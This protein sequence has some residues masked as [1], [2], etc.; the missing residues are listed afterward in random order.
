[1]LLAAFL[2]FYALDKNGYTNE[3]YA[4][5]VK[6]QLVSW[7]NFFFNAYDPAGFITLDKPPVAFWLETASAWLFGYS[8]VSI[9]IPSALAGMGS[10]LLVFQMVKK[11]FG[12]VAGLLA[13]LALAVTPIAVVMNRH[14]NPESILI[15]ILL[16]AA[17]GISK[18]VEQ[19][20]LRWL[21][22][23]VVMVGIGFNTKMMVAFIILPTFYALYFLMAPIKWWKRILHLGAATVVLVAVSLSWAVIVDLTP[24]DQR[25]YVGGSSNNS[26]INLIM[27]YNGVDRI[28]G[29]TPGG[30]GNAPGGVPFAIGN[31]PPQGFAG[32]DGMQPPQGVD[33]RP[34]DGGRQIDG[35]GF[36]PGGARNGIFAGQS[37]IT[38][39]FDTNY[40]GEAGWL[41]PIALLTL[42][43]GGVQNFR[44]FGKGTS[45]ERARRNQALF[46]WGGW[47]ITFMVV[48]SIAEGI[49]HNYYLVMLAP[50][51]AALFG[52][53][54]EVLWH[55]YKQGGWKSWLLPVVLVVSAVFEMH[56]LSS[57]SDWNRT[58]ALVVAGVELVAACALMGVPQLLKLKS[59]LW[60]KVVTAIAA[61]ALLVTPLAWAFNAIFAKSF[62][63][64]TLPTAIPSSG[65]T[66]S[67]TGSGL[68]ATLT[69]NW[70]SWL[71]FLVVGLAVIAVLNLVIRL[72]RLQFTGRRQ[73]ERAFAGIA[74]AVV[75]GLGVT[76]SFAALP[77][78]A[79]AA[80]SNGP[81]STGVIGN[82]QF[83]LGDDNKLIAY[84][85]ANY[86]GE[87]YLLATASSQNA[88]GLIIKTGLPIIAMGGFS[89]QDKTL[90][91]ADLQE[92]IQNR[93][94]RFFLLDGQGGMG[95]N[96]TASSYV[97]SS[98]TAVNSSLWSTSTG[99]TSQSQGIFGA[100]RQMGGS[101]G[102]LYDCAAK[103]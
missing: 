74:I 63:N 49:F 44:R 16:V 30:N 58:L 18:A 62:T 73:I 24:A 36:N 81:V 4:A 40:A 2:N 69:A 75:L 65:Q 17:W 64:A 22:L 100:V 50:A 103:S 5:A 6:S 77:T 37:S 8:G 68:W 56:I 59:L 92:M 31:Q 12:S 29:N 35:G 70:T 43:I 48:F 54:I 66:S 1:M 32:I 42:V 45:P 39:M 34:A 88:S 85:Q 86:N 91:T 25:P 23:S 83:G 55:A 96:S 72:V 13:G 57:Y 20:K 78:S 89:G 67:R 82:P 26:V 52:A 71:T 33:G 9:L 101:Q 102:T 95:G 93:E 11:A 84:L 90:T 21:M 28:E 27:E 76:M 3:Y 14:N 7:Q 99:S 97:R 38:R 98:C 15:F 41:L 60:A 61:L 80:T 10:V 53:G 87:K 47:L 19:G 51:A 46:L 94:V 79:T